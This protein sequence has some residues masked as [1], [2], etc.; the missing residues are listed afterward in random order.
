[1]Q[2][3]RRIS[4]VFYGWWIVG[5]CSLIAL[6][7]GA[8]V[9]LGF[10][11]FFEPIVEEF[12]WSYTQ[13]SLAASLQG[14]ELGLMAPV[15]G[16]LVDRGSPRRLLVVGAL[17]LCLSLLFLSRTANLAM[18]YFGCVLL[19]IG[20]S[21]TS[22]T[23][24]YTAIAQWFRRKMG[25]AS[26]IMSS[27]FA[28]GSMLVPLIS[29][30]ID[31]YD[32]RIAMLIL[33]ILVCITIL[34]L[35]FLVK[36]K[37]EQYGCLP[38]GDTYIRETL[39]TA[40]PVQAQ[41]DKDAMGVKEALLSRVF[42]HV[43]LSQ[44]F[45]Y[46]AVNTV[47]VHI[48]PYLSS[49]GVPRSTSSLI[50]AFTPL[51][52]IIGRISSGWL[53]DRLDKRFVCAVYIA[54][55]C[56]ALLILTQLTAAVVWLITIYVILM[57]IGWGGFTPLRSA[58]VRNYFGL[59]H[60]GIILGTMMGIMALVGM[61]G[62]LFAGWVFDTFSGYRNAWLVLAGIALVAVVIMV[63]TPKVVGG[64]AGLRRG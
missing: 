6:F 23:V 21:F 3:K 19:A 54:A 33:G 56:I 7:A 13:V 43:T 17:V 24:L 36:Y 48:M 52:S 44:T 1:M 18:F 58:M 15:V 31:S 51:V 47:V 46:M 5:A 39:D 60:Y 38:D 22:G 28:L 11:A 9:V 8:F 2:L 4:Q 55:T 42:W 59:R 10:T 62:P 50:A 35:S 53:G 64:A 27:G 32:W 41:I 16:L 29:W 63:T 14:A 20:Y 57:G 49:I 26:G 40:E 37:P 12:G 34:P 45:Q 25:L 61:G 30:M